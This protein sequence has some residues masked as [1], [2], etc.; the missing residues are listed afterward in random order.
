APALP[1]HV[2]SGSLV[3]GDGF[4]GSLT[5]VAGE[6]VAGSPYAIQQG[7][8]TAGSNYN[9]TFVGANLTITKRP[10]TVTADNKTKVYGNA[11][12]VF[13]YQ[14]TLGTVVSGDSFSGFPSRDSGD[15]VGSYAITQGS[16]T[17]GNNYNLTFVPGTLTITQ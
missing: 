3:G 14:V 13:T 10:V 7:T 11:D 4:S 6:T 9:L 2:S 1:N 17:L 15:S 5:R 16:L 8:L 12:P